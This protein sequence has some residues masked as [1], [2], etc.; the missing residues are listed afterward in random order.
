[1]LTVAKR[2]S[3]T[4]LKET[5]LR[6]VI[7]WKVVLIFSPLKPVRSALFAQSRSYWKEQ[8]HD[9]LPNFGTCFA[10]NQNEISLS[11]IVYLK[12]NNHFSKGTPKP[13]LS[14]F[15]RTRTVLDRWNSGYD[16]LPGAFRELTWKTPET[17]LCKTCIT[18]MLRFAVPNW[19][20]F[21]IR[22]LYTEKCSTCFYQ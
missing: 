3:F 18:L 13:R 8:T 1:M 12:Y 20:R 22:F 14:A 6:N 10:I 17:P 19:R 16:K 11:Y 21:Q 2:R 4:D 7:H 9:V 5:S 15:Y